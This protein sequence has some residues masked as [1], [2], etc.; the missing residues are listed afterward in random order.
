MTT[1]ETINGLFDS[2]TDLL[3]DKEMGLYDPISAQELQ[4]KVQYYQVLAE[5]EGCVDGEFLCGEMLRDG[6]EGP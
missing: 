4:S 2:H 1:L 5:S 6:F 3:V